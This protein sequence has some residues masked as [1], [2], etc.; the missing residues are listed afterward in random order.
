MNLI[1]LDS[2]C[3]HNNRMEIY[4][5]YKT[6]VYSKD[7]V[8][9]KAHSVKIISYRLFKFQLVLI[10]PSTWIFRIQIIVILSNKL[11]CNLIILEK[12]LALTKKSTFQI[13]RMHLINFQIIRV[14]EAVLTNNRLKN[15]KRF[16]YL[17]RQKK[18]SQLKNKSLHINKEFFSNKFLKNLLIYETYFNKVNI[19]INCINIII[20]LSNYKYIINL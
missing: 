9:S 6:K 17:Y 12:A 3:H 13:S 16:R 10:S 4:W 8:P 14:M 7:R 15:N 11:I 19:S 2:L 5:I 1:L 20:T 18:V